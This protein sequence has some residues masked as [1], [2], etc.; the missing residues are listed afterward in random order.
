MVTCASE[1]E[2]AFFGAPLKIQRSNI[3]VGE[4]YFKGINPQE[5][6]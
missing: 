4:L 6:L 2:R 3:M 1:A 5:K